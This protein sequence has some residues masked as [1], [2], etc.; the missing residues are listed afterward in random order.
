MKGDN[1]MAEAAAV[2]FK[3]FRARYNT[4]DA[5]RR[6]LL[7]L[8]AP[9][10]RDGWN[11]HASHPSAVDHMV[12]GDLSFCNGQARCF[13]GSA[14]PHFGNLLRHSLAFVG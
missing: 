9:D 8:Q 5:C 11:R 3:E 10:L 2:T 14:E 12:L 6:E 13:C 1:V 4:E 7:C